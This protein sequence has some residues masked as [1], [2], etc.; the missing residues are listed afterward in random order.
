MCSW[1]VCAHPRHAH[2]R[3]MPSRLQAAGHQCHR[4][5]TLR[6][7]VVIDARA[8]SMQPVRLWPLRGPAGHARV[9]PLRARPVLVQPGAGGVQ[10]VPARQLQRLDLHGAALPGV[11]ARAAVGLHRVPRGHLPGRGR[12]E[13]LPGLPSWHLLPSRLLQ[14]LCVPHWLH[15][16][17]ALREL[18]AVPARVPRGCRGAAQVQ[19]LPQGVVQHRVRRG[20]VQALPRRLL[21][22]LRAGPLRAVPQGPLHSV[23][24]CAALR[25]LQGGHVCQQ[26]G[27]CH[28]LQKLP[29]RLHLE[30]SVCPPG[31]V[32]P[33]PRQHL[34]AAGRQ[35]HV[36]ALPA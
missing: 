13:L 8:G 31:R 29:S 12:Q 19:G 16:A 34:P 14:V 30:R 27:Q 17:A 23:R 35:H 1:H 3:A 28:A 5:H 33:L 22:L 32:H 10:G 9:L 21:L 24:R 20:P 15:L 25:A 2:M 7:G 4:V 26:P 11:A 18:H 6:Q 36:P